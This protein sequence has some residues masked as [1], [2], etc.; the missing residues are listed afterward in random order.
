MSERHKCLSSNCKVQEIMA[1]TKMCHR[2]I[3]FSLQNILV[4]IPE[5]TAAYIPSICI[6]ELNAKTYI[7]IGVLG[8]GT[9]ET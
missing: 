3:I 7:A 9:K 8:P 2:F 5:I 4:C 6:E 1:K